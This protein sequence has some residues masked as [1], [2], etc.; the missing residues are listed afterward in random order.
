MIDIMSNAGVIC[1]YYEVG[2]REGKEQ[3]EGS[4]MPQISL[5]ILN[6]TAV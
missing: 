5:V 1:E 2:G 3:D 4:I 6:G